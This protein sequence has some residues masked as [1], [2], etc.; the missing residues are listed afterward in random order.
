MIGI[1]MYM[2]IKTLHNL[3]KNKSEISRL[4]GH[5]WKTVDKIIKKIEFGIEKPSYKDRKSIVE[6]FKERV[7]ELLGAD[8]S[9]VRIH[10]ELVKDGF[11]GSYSAVKKYIRKLNNRR[12][13]AIRN[14]EHLH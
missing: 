3:G 13:Y 8:L 11:G 14:F 2:T 5:D 6:E 4:T 10:Q 1:A 7:L 12:A 9:G